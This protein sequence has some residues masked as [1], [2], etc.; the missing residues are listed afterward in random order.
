MPILA[1][2]L[3]SEEERGRIET[4]VA[5]RSRWQA[6]LLEPGGLYRCTHSAALS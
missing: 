4:Q 1:E 5:Q 3:M 6:V 2:S